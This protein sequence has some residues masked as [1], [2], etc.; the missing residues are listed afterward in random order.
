MNMGRFLLVV[1]YLIVHI[2]SA[3]QEC[4]VPRPQRVKL[5]SICS[6][7]KPGSARVPF[8]LDDGTSCWFQCPGITSY[9][10]LNGDAIKELRIARLRQNIADFSDRLIPRTEQPK[11][12]I[13]FQRNCPTT[14]H[15]GYQPV[16]DTIFLKGSS[17]RVDLILSEIAARDSTLAMNIGCWFLFEVISEDPY[18]AH[19]EPFPSITEENTGTPYISIP[20]RFIDHPLVGEELFVF[21]ILHEIGHALSDGHCE[22]DAEQWAISEGMPAYYGD[23]ASTALRSVA[24]QLWAYNNAIFTSDSNERSS[25]DQFCRGAGGC[26]N[27]YPK[28]DCRCGDIESGIVRWNEDRMPGDCWENIGD[29]SPAHA[30]GSTCDPCQQ[31][32]PLIPALCQFSHTL[33][34][35]LERLDREIRARLCGSTRAPCELDAARIRVELKKLDRRLLRRFERTQLEL[36]R[37][38]HRATR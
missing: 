15:A 7:V 21:M 32:C 24:T 26:M 8:N 14:T 35:D 13:L 27:C 37:I 34:A 2:T 22:S 31:S 29:P 36:Q 1:T 6:H 5:E 20:K 30:C 25:N 11:G 23:R 18:D 9:S 4:A 16:A 38:H 28:I 3:Q 17:R 33:N 10:P 12:R 19:C